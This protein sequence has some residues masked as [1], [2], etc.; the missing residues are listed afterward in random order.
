MQEDSRI[1]FRQELLLSNQ[2]LAATC[3]LLSLAGAACSAAYM[4]YEVIQYPALRSYLH[5]YPML[6]YLLVLLWA[7]SWLLLK[8][9]RSHYSPEEPTHHWRGYLLIYWPAALLLLTNWLLALLASQATGSFV[10]AC[11]YAFTLV[12]LPFFHAIPRYLQLVLFG[13]LQAACFMLLYRTGSPF[14]WPVLTGTTIIG[15]VLYVISQHFL[16]NSSRQFHAA[17]AMR[18]EYI[19]IQ[20]GMLRN[21]EQLRKTVHDLRNPVA[22]IQLFTEFMLKYA[23]EN[24]P[25]LTDNLESVLECCRQ[26][27]EALNEVSKQRVA[28]TPQEK[29]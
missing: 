2:D 28:S 26:M 1:A 3:T 25:E 13:L 9:I 12:L 7:A 5:F 18:Q 27:N 29:G 14:T 17:H 8:Y 21:N 23:V 24:D 10:F 6:F 20:L 4:Q 19:E 16:A 11:W 15:I 22:S